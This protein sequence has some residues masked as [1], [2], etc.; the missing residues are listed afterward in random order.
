YPSPSQ[1]SGPRRQPF[2]RAG[3]VLT[4]TG[5]EFIQIVDGHPSVQNLADSPKRERAGTGLAVGEYW[6]VRAGE[7][8]PKGAYLLFGDVTGHYGNMT[9]T[10]AQTGCDPSRF[11]RGGLTRLLA[12]GTVVDDTDNASR[13]GIREVLARQLR[14][15]PELF[16]DLLQAAVSRSGACPFHR[17]NQ[18]GPQCGGPGGTMPPGDHE[19][20]VWS[21]RLDRVQHHLVELVVVA[22]HKPHRHLPRGAVDI[23]QTEKLETGRGRQVRTL[24]RRWG[25]NEFQ[26]RPEGHVEIVGAE[27]AGM[28]RSGNEF[29]E[30]V[31]ILEGRLVRIVV[32]GGGIMHVRSEPDRVLDA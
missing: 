6:S 4:E 11:F 3:K 27:G 19:M 5:P 7:S 20:V 28:Q 17:Y 10:Q 13:P 12:V 29:P 8:V 30:G 16:I 14:S 9:V 25:F 2:L 15:D 18:P 1:A 22:I 23:H 21:G 32:M 31:E 24:L 26:L